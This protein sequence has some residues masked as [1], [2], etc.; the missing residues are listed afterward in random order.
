MNTYGDIKYLCHVTSQ[1]Q[2]VVMLPPS[3]YVTTFPS[4]LAIGIVVVE[5]F[6]VCHAI[7]QDHVIKRA[8]DYS[9]NLPSLVVI[10]NVV[11]EIQWF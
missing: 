10:G 7:K 5:I 11:V 8:G 1:N 2:V 9:D 3:W 6:L 4:L